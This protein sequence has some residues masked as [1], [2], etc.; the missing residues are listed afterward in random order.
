MSAAWARTTWARASPACHALART[1]L[2]T[3]PAWGSAACAPAAPNIPA[4]ESPADAQVTE[5]PSAS[6]LAEIDGALSGGDPASRLGLP[7]RRDDVLRLLWDLELSLETGQPAL[8]EV[9]APH[10]S[11]SARADDARPLAVS[12]SALAAALGKTGAGRLDHFDF[13]RATLE[14]V[15]TGRSVRVSLWLRAAAQGSSRD[16]NV[17]IT[18]QRWGGRLRIV[19]VFVSD[20]R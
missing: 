9:L 10:A 20:A 2:A 1:L 18:M 14:L 13:D 4:P 12:P 11:L 8:G 19:G 7:E 5:I 3:S 15:Q 6:E 17:A 16:R